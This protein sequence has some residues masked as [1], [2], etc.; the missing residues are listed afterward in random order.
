MALKKYLTLILFVFI[1]A[2]L[3]GQQYNFTNYSIEHGIAQSQIKAF[4]EDS[5][6]YLWIGTDGGGISVFDGIKF[7]T[8]SQEDG[9]S[10]NQI[11][12]LYEDRD[13]N[14]WVGLKDGYL[15]KF[16][17][18]KFT[19]YGEKK[20]LTS[21]T[22]Q[23]ITQ[24][25]AGNLWIGTQSGLFVMRDDKIQKVALTTDSADVNVQTFLLD[26]YGKLWIGTQHHGAYVN[27][28]L[29]FKQLTTRN[30]LC[31]NSIN[32]ISEDIKGHIWFGT[33]YGVSEYDGYKFYNLFQE[34]GLS[35][36]NVSSV[37]S[38][39]S[40]NIWF[41]YL[42]QGVSRFNGR[43]YIHFSRSNG[44]SYDYINSILQDRSGN[45]WFSTDGAGICKF[46]GERFQHFTEKDGLSSNV[47]MSLYEDTQNNIWFGTYGGGLCKYN[48]TEFE[49]FTT[50]DGLC[51]NLIYRIFED[52]KGNLWFG[53]KGGGLSIYDGKRFKNFNSSN[54]LSHDYIYSI[55][56]DKLGNILIGSVGGGLM[57][58][59]GKE[60]TA[61]REKDGISSDLIYNV[62]QDSK[63]N[64]WLGTDDAG[65]D[66]IFA[67]YNSNEIIKNK[68]IGTNNI[69]NLSRRFG[70]TK[71]QI[72]SIAEDM[73]GNVWFGS[74]GGGICRFNGA[75][76]KTFSMRDGLNS[77]NVFLLFSDSQGY[78]W[79]GTEKGL[80]RI[81]F[82]DGSETP[83]IKTYGKSEG[84]RA[85]EANLNAVMEDH[86]GFIW[87]G[88]IQGATMYI[89]NFDYPNIMEPLT[90]ISS[91]KLFFQDTDWSQ[92]VDSLE[93]W[94]TLPKKLV[95]PYDQNHLTFSFTGIDFHAPEK[96]KYEWILEGFDKKWAPP[97]YN[98][99]IIYS[100]IPPGDYTFKVKACNNDGVC[101][102]EPKSFSF[103]ISPPFWRTWWFYTVTSI[104][105][106]ALITLFVRWRLKKLE[107]EKEILEEKVN[108]RTMELQKEKAVVEQQAEEIRAQAENMANVNKELEKLSIVASE[109]ENSVMIADNEG[110]IEWVNEGFRK[111][112]GYT[113]D[114]FRILV[115]ENI[116]HSSSNPEIEEE[117]KKC[118]EKKK[119]IVYNAP[120]KT[121]NGKSIW[122]QTTLTPIL[123][124]EGEIRK[125]VAIDSDISSIKLAEEEIKQQNEEIKAQ[126][127]QLNE[128]YNKMKELE[129]FKDSFTSMIVHDMKNHLN[130]IITF[131]GQLFTEKNLKNINQAG[132]QML[133]MVLNMLDVQKF[134]DTQVQLNKNIHN[135]LTVTKSAISDVSILLNEKGLTLVNGVKP[136]YQSDY[137]YDII[138]RVI[139][140][141]MTNAIKYTESG[142]K[143]T[144][145]TVPEIENEKEFIKIS[146]SDTGSGIPP[147]MIDSI[148]NPFTQVA[149]KKSGG[150][151]STG[152]GL[153]FCKLVVEAHGGRIWVESELGKGSNF[154]FT[155][156]RV[157]D[158]NK[159]DV[160]KLQEEEQRINTVELT[161]E[162][163][164]K[165]GPYILRFEDNKIYEISKNLDILNKI[166]LLNNTENI[167]KW[168]DRVESAIFNF[169]NDAL[170]KLLD[171]VRK[172]D[173]NKN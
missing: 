24:D 121:K 37:F 133:N 173:A 13:G 124:D 65:V 163:V 131:S 66:L 108:Q 56:E 169:N 120:A 114:E 153:T 50:E 17:G 67:D 38:D 143:I 71:D 11:R 6:G 10:N 126:R 109:T 57:I 63:G 22:V 135:I 18:V 157:V 62:F 51:S 90:S 145:N 137:D 30:G 156:P 34:N 54:G 95:L 106:L 136:Q 9:L 105:S 168:A 60:F 172:S 47:V 92:Y 53:S 158:S 8:Y 167:E 166:K 142:G 155:I 94:G 72:Y 36:N 159:E 29:K 82:Y 77:N 48:G 5:R 16:N 21:P 61:I 44:L 116:L 28:N 107:L 127:D 64:I 2:T 79:A 146:I 81:A 129:I 85:I 102:L 152:I 117:F 42:G 99:E 41:S 78:L 43:E 171:M 165:I 39:R 144:L 59:D 40:G 74:F 69:L 52:S 75:D 115:G 118:T 26:K 170:N 97:S 93:E 12:A 110:T 86:R 149:A 96:V 148:F 164:M 84:F 128:A 162:E 132:K 68:K 70:L 27:D 33:R 140:N 154:F 141:L 1:Y 25:V 123:N 150:A 46:D 4:I 130:S 134:E 161:P 160:K 119:S 20:G 3:L 91:I 87:F 55:I 113:L 103:T 49:Y 73:S 15:C 23:A 88:N 76:L 147:N 111:L 100:Y 104:V 19:P 80:N 112:Y 58:Y 7:K 14:I 139:V 101:N 32:S 45:M 125:Y 98:N 151:S 89:P 83:V 35:G 138:Q 122:V 31:N